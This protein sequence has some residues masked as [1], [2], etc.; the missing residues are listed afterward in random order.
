MPNYAEMEWLVRT[1]DVQ[2]RVMTLAPGDGTPWHYHSH[3]S[4]DVFGLDPG[5]Q[6]AFRDPDEV[7]PI[8]PGERAHVAAGRVHRVVNAS[9]ARA[10]YLLIQATGAYDFNEVT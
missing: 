9:A 8:G 10:R 6:I 1:A 5:V 4:D 7:R 2:V 3:V